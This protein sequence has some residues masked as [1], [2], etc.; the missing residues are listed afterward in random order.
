MDTPN[1]III[2]ID[3]LRYDR[4]KNLSN[5]LEGFVDYG[6]AIT[7]APWTLPSHVSL[8]TGLYPSIHGSHE[9]EDLT[10]RDI[11]T[12]RNKNATLMTKLKRLGYTTYCFSANS[13]ISE[14]YGFEGFDIISNWFDSWPQFLAAMDESSAKLFQRY[15]DSRTANNLLNFLRCLLKRNKRLLTNIMLET[16]KL[17]F[18]GLR[19]DLTNDKGTSQA[20]S[21][22]KRT[23]FREPFFLFMNLL[24]VHEPYLRDDILFGKDQSIV[25]TN[26][27]SREVLQ[28]WV[29]GYDTRSKSIS[30]DIQKILDILRRKG[31]LENT[32]VILTSDHGQ[33]LGE[34]GFAGH[35]VFLFDELVQVPLLIKYPTSHRFRT[36]QGQEYVSLTSIPQFVL[37]LVQGKDTDAGLFTQEAFSESWGSYERT[38]KSH[39]KI[40]QQ[41][42]MIARRIC[43]YSGGGKVTYNLSSDKVEEFLSSG[44]EPDEDTLNQLVRKCIG[45]ARLN[46]RL[47]ETLYVPRIQS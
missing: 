28:S 35:G 47:L 36:R 12:I 44:T 25:P 41:Y 33:L 16:A 46:E 23:S 13:F 9:T 38:G 31:V 19:G 18:F 27:L 6:R 17:V 15:L 4:G 42:Q 43:V 2:V 39:S 32:V 37:D 30:G 21:F 5:T 40:A 22:V 26:G 1:I 29:E 34:H 11:G 10:W 45:F 8:L 24:Q 3:S 20:M 7:A 14:V